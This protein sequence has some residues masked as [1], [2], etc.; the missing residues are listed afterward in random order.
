M[1]ENSPVRPASEARR[2]RLLIQW[3]MLLAILFILGFFISR[4]VQE[5]GKAA[6]MTVCKANIYFLAYALHVYHDTEGSFPPA[7]VTD[8]EGNRLYSWRVLLSP[9]CDQVHFFEAYDLTQSWDDPENLELANKIDFIGFTCPSGPNSDDPRDK[10]FVPGRPRYTDYVAVVG[11]G[12]AF[13]GAEAVSLEAITDG[14]E[15]TILLVEIAHSDIHWSEPRDLN[16]DG[17]SFRINDPSKPSISSLHNDGPHVVFA[18]GRSA[19]LSEAIPPDILKALLT[20]DGGEKIT[21]RDL[22]TQGHLK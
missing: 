4:R 21:R 13:P 1:S 17:M 14:P 19:R 16:F 7:F 9:Y 12:T 15:N 3:S 18:D 5:A 2:R 11:P 8:S 20:I 10:D 6:R 22:E